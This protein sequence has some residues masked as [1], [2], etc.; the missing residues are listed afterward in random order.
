MKDL[1]AFTDNR[2]RLRN[3]FDE[4]IYTRICKSAPCWGEFHDT[5]LDDANLAEMN[6][7]YLGNEIQL[8]NFSAKRADDQEIVKPLVCRAPTVVVY[9][10]SPQDTPCLIHSSSSRFRIPPEKK[11]VLQC[12]N[13][14]ITSLLK[15][16]WTQLTEE[17]M[18][19]T[20]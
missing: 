7:L 1:K 10:E 20:N 5:L 19:R 2:R 17:R 11:P 3:S 16:L 8:P 14:S 9:T 6:T 4:N 13:V 15:R 18:E 12:C